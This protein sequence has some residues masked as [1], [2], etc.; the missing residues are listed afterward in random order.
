MSAKNGGGIEL[1]NLSY[2]VQNKLLWTFH[3]TKCYKSDNGT[4]IVF[5]PLNQPGEKLR[6]TTWTRSAIR[7]VA[8]SVRAVPS[9]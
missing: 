9:E 1:I 5:N 3:V 8:F 4:S 7:Y 2:I 6:N